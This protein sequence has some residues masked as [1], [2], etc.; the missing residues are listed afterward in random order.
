MKIRTAK[1]SDVPEWVRMRTA[2]W[3]ES[4]EDHPVEIEQF[5]AEPRDDLATF[6]AEDANGKLCGFL[7]A[8]TRPYAEGCRSSPVG[9]VEGWWVDPE[10][11]NKGVGADLVLAAEAWARESGMTEMASDADIANEVS[12]SAHRALGYRE[13]DRLVCFRKDL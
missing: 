12:Q 1:P 8:G 7:E 4:P 2:L 11:R 10:H 6:V 13:T 5:F 9:Y 3:S